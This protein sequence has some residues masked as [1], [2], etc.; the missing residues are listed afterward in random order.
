[1]ASTPLGTAGLAL[2]TALVATSVRAEIVRVAVLRAPALA[3]TGQALEVRSSLEGPGVAVGSELRIELVGP[4][5]SDGERLAPRLWIDDAT[6]GPLTVGG[7]RLAGPLEVVAT[8]DALL[9][10]DL[11]ELETYVASVVGAEMPA[12][13]PRAALESQAVAARTYV[14]KKIVGAGPGAEFHVHASVLHQVYKG[15]ESIDARTLAAA[16]A[17]RGRVLEWEGALAEAFFFAHCAGRTETGEDA[18]G[19]GAP[20]LRNVACREVAGAPGLTWSRRLPLAGLSE[21]LRASGAIG[22][23]LTDVEVVSRTAG[24]RVASARLVTRHGRRTIPGPELRRLVGYR[25]LPSLDF[26]VRREAGA[27]VFS[28]RGAGHAVGLCQW[29]AR[30]MAAAGLDSGAIL[31]HFYPGTSLRNLY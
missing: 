10:I 4:F 31:A 13:W 21:R 14:L 28:G 9:A 11:V 20:Y 1:M 24:G 7:V 2:A 25:E 27:L 5:V 22:D 26:E 3:V 8:A 18:F 17:T 29:C 23:E 30:G 19:R 15:R 12:G 6:G 16:A